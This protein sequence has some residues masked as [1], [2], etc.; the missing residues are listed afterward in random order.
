MIKWIATLLVVMSFSSIALDALNF[1]QMQA[2]AQ[3]KWQKEVL[4]NI[5]AEQ[6][7]VAAKIEGKVHQLTRELTTL[8]FLQTHKNKGI[9]AVMIVMALAGILFFFNNKLGKNDALILLMSLLIS[10]SS[11]Y[12]VTLIF[13]SNFPESSK[14]VSSISSAYFFFFGILAPLFF[15]LPIVVQNKIERNGAINAPWIRTMLKS[16]FV[17]FIATSIIL[18]MLILAVPDISGFKN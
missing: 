6:K 13:T 2:S 11:P 8:K 10:M 3:L 18:V 14:G 4:V 12:L 5:T 9:A 15:Y 16:V 7:D 17:L 1:S